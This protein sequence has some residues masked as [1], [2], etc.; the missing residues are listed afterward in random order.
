MRFKLLAGRHESGSRKEGTLRYYSARDRHTGLY[1]KGP[2]GKEMP[3]VIE[4]D[5][6]LARMFGQN[7]FQLLPDV[8]T[9]S[10]KC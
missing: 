8:K 4:T 5:K 9:S 1:K 10:K 6:D 3:D 7:K 2:D